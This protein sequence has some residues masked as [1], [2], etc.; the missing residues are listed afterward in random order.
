M[1]KK[2]NPKAV[3]VNGI[4]I[5]PISLA[6]HRRLDK[7]P[8]RCPQNRTQ[9]RRSVKG[10]ASSVQPPHPVLPQIQWLDMVPDRRRPV[11]TSVKLQLVHSVGQHA[12][13]VV[14]R[15][16][17]FQALMDDVPYFHAKPIDGRSER[18]LEPQCYTQPALNVSHRRHRA[19]N[20]RFEFGRLPLRQKE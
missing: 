15:V 1:P 12:F 8:P 16:E 9:R 18:N 7:R 13:S 2:K 14:L 10:S 3:M 11:L 17:P 20:L 6:E 4:P 19:G 5:K